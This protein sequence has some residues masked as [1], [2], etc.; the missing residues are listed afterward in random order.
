[1]KSGKLYDCFVFNDLKRVAIKNHNLIEKVK[2]FM[3]M[4]VE[5]SSYKISRIPS[6]H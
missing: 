2:F 6:I 1:M 4:N 3:D 5:H